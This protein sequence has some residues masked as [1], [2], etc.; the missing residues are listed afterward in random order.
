MPTAHPILCPV[1]FSEPS[2]RALVWASTIAHRGGGELIAL[3]ASEPLL[4]Q[5]AGIRLGVDL[6][7]T[8]TRPALGAFVQDTL[9][10][11]ARARAAVHV[12]ATVGD[13]ADV[14]LRTARRRKAGLIVMGTHGRGGLRKLLLGSTTEQV[15]RRAACPV[16]AVPAAGRPGHPARP[17]DVG[18]IL[19]ATDF[20]GSAAVAA[21]WAADLAFD[22]EAR[23]IVAHVVEPLVVPRRWQALAAD[24]EED[25]VGAARERLARLAR[26]LSRAPVSSALAVGAPSESIAALAVEHRAGL[27]VLGR[28]NAGARDSPAPGAIAYRVLRDAAVP[29]LVV[30]DRVRAPFVHQ[31]PAC[32]T[33][34]HDACHPAHSERERTPAGRS[35]DREPHPDDHLGA[36]AR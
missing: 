21:R 32:L 20:R 25:R 23:L 5:A 33:G 29:V 19:L 35:A 12:I 27:V 2:R 16:L 30:P 8:D 22:L 24:S 14:I 34:T 7:A 9:P 28:P 10:A 11:D 15:L 3:F 1:D 4:A 6:T 18:R 26:N 36:A 31:P 17:L 13:P